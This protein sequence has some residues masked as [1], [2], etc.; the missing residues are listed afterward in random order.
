[1]NMFGTP[2]QLN[3]PQSD[4]VY[5]SC[6]GGCLSTLVIIV[7]LVFLLQNLKVMMDRSGTQFSAT[8]RKGGLLDASCSYEDGFKVAFAVDAPAILDGKLKLGA[9]IHAKTK[10]N[11]IHKVELDMAPCRHNIDKDVSYLDGFY[12]I[13]EY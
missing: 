5:R 3:Y 7:T 9:Y 4:G 2:I 8:E 12:A 13:A 6:L 10:E 11:K 1:M